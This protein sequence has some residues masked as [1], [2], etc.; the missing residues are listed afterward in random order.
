MKDERKSQP[1][2]VVIPGK[3]ALV[4]TTNLYIGYAYRRISDM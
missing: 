4:T 2:E 1:S 3:Y